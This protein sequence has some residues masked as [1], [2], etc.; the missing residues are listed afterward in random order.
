V[1]ERIKEVEGCY[2][3][4]DEPAFIAEAVA[5]VLV[6]GKR[7]S[8]AYSAV[9]ELSLA[10]VARR[11]QSYNLCTSGFFREAAGGERLARGARM[12]NEQ[13]AIADEHF[14]GDDCTLFSKIRKRSVCPM[15]R[16]TAADAE[17]G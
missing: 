11:I 3:V 16:L 14:T 15:P 2:I 10:K 9:D 7:L 4:P 1:A 13:H 17:Q 5:K 12:T 8:G 6:R